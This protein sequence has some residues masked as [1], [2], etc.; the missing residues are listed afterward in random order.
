MKNNYITIVIVA[1]VVGAIGFFAGTKYQQSQRSM[2]LQGGQN[3]FRQR[4]GQNANNRAVRG[5]IVSVDDQGITIK[6]TDGSTKNVFLSSSTSITKA[7]AAA[8]TDLKAG[9][10]VVV[11]GQTNADGSVTAQNVSLNPSQFGGG[12]RQSTPSAQ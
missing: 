6:L 8:K 1:I 12:E 2:V 10:A 7:T 4:S 5:E 9:E 3:G 11:F